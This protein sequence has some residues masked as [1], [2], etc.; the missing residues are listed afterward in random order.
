MGRRFDVLRQVI[1]AWKAKDVEAVLAHMSD[2]IVWHFAAA[3]LP[4]V[5]GKAEARKLLTRFQADMHEI[6]WRIF[7]SVETGDRLFVEGVDEY[8]NAAGTWI[9][10]PYAGVL[11]FIG[12]RISGWRDYVDTSVIAAQREGVE[13]SA[14][15]KALIQRPEAT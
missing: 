1:E 13:P 5:C 11:D 3:A 8:R 15:V 7:A 4:P 14:Q 2:D 6:R 10:A 12:D 9:A